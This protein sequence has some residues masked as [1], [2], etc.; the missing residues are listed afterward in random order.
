M[1]WRGKYIGWYRL[2]KEE[3]GDLVPTLTENE[4][5]E[6]VSSED[7]L[8]VPHSQT[9]KSIPKLFFKLTDDKIT[10]GVVYDSKKMIDHLLN[11]WKEYHDK[12]RTLLFAKLSELDPRYETRLYKV[13]RDTGKPEILRN[14]VA[15]RMDETLLKRVID[16][17]DA[18]RRGGRQE[19]GNASVYVQPQNPV[20]HFIEVKTPL[21]PEEFKHALRD[22]KPIIELLMNIKTQREIIKERLS[23]P[24]KKKNLYKE[25]VEILNEARRKDLITAERRRE[26]NQKWRQH[27]EDREELVE[28]LNRMVNPTE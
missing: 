28:E 10:V 8:V 13:P 5:M 27:E 6:N 9:E 16:E 22:M 1:A 17:A 19:I 26:L 4:V 11:I 24:A 23:K 20:I 14:Y 7:V 25:F 18:L 3:Y 21:N 12:D 15:S 2:L